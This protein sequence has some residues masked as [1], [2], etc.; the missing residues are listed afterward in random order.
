[1]RINMRFVKIHHN[2][3]EYKIQ[4]PN[5]IFQ[6]YH[7]NTHSDMYESDVPDPGRSESSMASDPPIVDSPDMLESLRRETVHLWETDNR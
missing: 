7:S 5:I 1:M 4:K 2:T 6:Y 3:Y